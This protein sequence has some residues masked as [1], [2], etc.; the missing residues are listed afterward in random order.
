M[1]ANNNTFCLEIDVEKNIFRKWETL[2]DNGEYKIAFAVK[3][4]NEAFS[5]SYT[6]G[7]GISS[8][9]QVKNDI[10][11]SLISCDDTVEGIS[12]YFESNGFFLNCT[13]GFEEFDIRSI[14]EA[15]NVI[16]SMAF[17]LRE[18]NSECPDYDLLLKHF[19]KLTTYD[20]IHLKGHYLPSSFNSDCEGSTFDVEAPYRLCFLNT[21]SSVAFGFL[22]RDINNGTEV[23]EMLCYEQGIS[24]KRINNKFD[25]V[26]NRNVAISEFPSWDRSDYSAP[27]MAFSDYI[28][29][30]YA[31][32]EYIDQLTLDTFSFYYHLSE[33]HRKIEDHFAIS[34]LSSADMD[35]TLKERLKNLCRRICDHYINQGIKDIRPL[36]NF[37]K[38]EK[39][40]MIPNLISALFYNLYLFDFSRYT[41]EECA[42]PNCHNYFI[43]LRNSPKSLYCCPAH[44]RS[45]AQA[46]LRKRKMKHT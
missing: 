44:A 41:Y 18:L 12:A 43:K 24:Y 23:D 32:S 5:Y 36:A 29:L 46:A 6:H 21:C 45:E 30:L 33:A 42:K 4:T 37:E 31:Y 40:I 19:Y 27:D 8:T 11:S 28:P 38:G 10:I 15:K 9:Q 2:L 14:L 39:V 17:I 25:F 13:N 7:N 26:L 35:D 34:A 22:E 3:A 20:G 1:K 16:T